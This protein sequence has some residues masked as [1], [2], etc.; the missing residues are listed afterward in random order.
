MMQQ[1]EVSGSEPAFSAALSSIH[2]QSMQAIVTQHQQLSPHS[3]I[4]ALESQLLAQFKTKCQQEMQA[5]TKQA[6]AKLLYTKREVLMEIKALQST[7]KTS[8]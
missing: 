1:R 4:E 6:V 3:P 2:S 7:I 5:Q 8:Q